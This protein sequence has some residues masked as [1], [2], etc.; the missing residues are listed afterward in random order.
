MTP[1]AKTTPWRK[2]LGA[3]LMTHRDQEKRWNRS[4]AA[5]AA[6]IDP[7]TLRRIE[8]GENVEVESMERYA[9][10]L[11]RPL[12]AWIRDVLRTLVETQPLPEPEPVPSRT[13]PAAVGKR[14]ASHR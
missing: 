12:E 13:K 8:R 14:R 6:H 4:V 5:R 9:A 10:A 7:N 1:A 2:R 11:G 3:L